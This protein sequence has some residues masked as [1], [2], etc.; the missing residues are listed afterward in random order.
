MDK[1]Y[2][3]YDTVFTYD[4]I[5]NS[6][7]ELAGYLSEYSDIILDAVEA[8]PTKYNVTSYLTDLE[9]TSDLLSDEAGYDIYEVM[10]T[11]VNAVLKYFKIQ[12]AKAVTEKKALDPSTKDPSSDLESALDV[13]DLVFVYFFVAAGLTLIF[14]ALL[15]ALNKKGKLGTGDWAAIALR[16][17]MGL[18][19]ALISLVATNY[20]AQGNFLDSVWMLPT[21][22]MALLV[23]VVVDGV[24]GWVFPATEAQKGQNGEA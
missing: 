8:D 16:T 5:S 7:E 14:M 19:L 18:A 24:F 23:V 10:Y 3:V 12:A 11:L 17:A 1:A 6:T 21:V 13:Y 22:M 9:S 15:I 4:Y 2:L 20:T